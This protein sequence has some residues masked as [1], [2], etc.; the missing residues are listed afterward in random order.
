MP[1]QALV[2]NLTSSSL[3]GIQ[4]NNQQYSIKNV[5]GTRTERRTAAESISR[6]NSRMWQPPLRFN[7]LSS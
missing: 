4:Y 1:S 6:P 7:M 3:I 5:S 2:K